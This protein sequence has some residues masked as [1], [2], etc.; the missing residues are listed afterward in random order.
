MPDLYMGGDLIN[1]TYTKIIKPKNAVKL[2]SENFK[3][4][5]TQVIWHLKIFGFFFLSLLVMNI[6]KLSFL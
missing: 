2:K 4:T 1:L 5:K 6:V 3:R